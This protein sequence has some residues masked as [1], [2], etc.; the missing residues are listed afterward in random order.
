MMNCKAS[1]NA[2]AM[3]LTSDTFVIV[4]LGM[5]K[6]VDRVLI[7]TPVAGAISST[8]IVCPIFTIPMIVFVAVHAASL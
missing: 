4:M 8:F 2:I 7:T 6:V 1:A 5:V 3:Y